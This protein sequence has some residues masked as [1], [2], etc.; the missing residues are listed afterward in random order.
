M[1]SFYKFRQV[2]ELRGLLT[3]IFDLFAGHNHD[4]ANSRLV[5]TGTPAAGAVG[6]TELAANALAA[7]TA[8]RGKIAT[9]FFDAATLLLKFAASCFAADT[10]TR[11]LFAAGIFQLTHLAATAKTHILTYRIEDL[12]ANADIADRVV[13]VVPA[14]LNLTI[15]GAE[16]VPEG[17]AAGVDDSN[18][19][20]IALKNGSDA[21]ASKTYNTSAP[22]PD[23]GVPGD[24]GALDG[25]YKVLAAGAKLCLSV[26]NGTTA[27]PA[28]MLLQVTYTVADAA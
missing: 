27:N 7:S 9:G 16:I 21:I 1:A 18:T 14:G 15:T 20:I 3:K 17:A 28:G 25:T 11:A 8:G 5:T 4:G 10:A 6:T 24:L 26:T 19:C 13:L 12:A 2:S 22:V 23:A